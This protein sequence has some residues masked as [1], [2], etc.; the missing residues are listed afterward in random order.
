M[1]HI[2]MPLVLFSVLSQTAIGLAIMNSC[3]HWATDGPD[4]DGRRQWE[5]IL[6]FLIT[7]MI[8][9]FFHLGHP[10]Q[11]YTALNH[12]GQAWLSWELLG[13]SIFLCLAVFGFFVAGKNNGK[14]LGFAAALVGLF[15]LFFMGMTYSPPSYPAINN[16]LPTVFFLLTALLL[17]SSCSTWFTS[18]ANKLWLSRILTVSLIVGL[19][20]Y[21]IVPCIWLSGG[22]VMAETGWT[23]IHSPLY[24][25]RIGIGLALPLIL[26]SWTKSIPPWL[27]LLIL[28]G[29]LMG[30]A[31][32]FKDTLHA[33]GN[34]G[35]LY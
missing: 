35:G 3:K 24:W 30:R 28:V 11:A 23:W 1:S 13:I 7:G 34:I 6:A 9:S 31:S 17:G 4:E 21:L 8:A 2:E 20:V 12:L 18:P 15:T 29:E 10:L 16:V 19:V 26:L 32:F 27:P 22:T 14:L 33:A 25:G 5:I